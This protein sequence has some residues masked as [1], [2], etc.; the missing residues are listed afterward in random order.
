MFN[1][2]SKL[3]LLFQKLSSIEPGELNEENFAPIKIKYKVNSFQEYQELLENLIDSENNVSKKGF[4]VGEYDR[5]MNQ[6]S[7]ILAAISSLNNPIDPKDYMEFAKGYCVGAKL[8][9]KEKEFELNKLKGFIAIK[10]KN[11]KDIIL[12][13][14][15]DQ[16]NE[17]R[18]V[19]VSIGKVRKRTG[20]N[21]ENFDAAV[22]NMS[23][24]REVILLFHDYPA[25]ETEEKR[26]E[27]IVGPN[28][29]YYHAIA[30]PHIKEM[31]R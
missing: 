9:T 24:N 7:D 11:I 12:K 16:I 10:E 2:I 30:L 21:K 19:V 20:L 23:E 6:A 22:W 18:T 1:S 29:Y 27:M 26:N 3:S 13:A 28:G 5:V 17:E 4:L 25:G 15:E 31:R 8:S 14:I